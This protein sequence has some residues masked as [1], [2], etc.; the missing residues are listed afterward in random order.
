MKW[1]GQGCPKKTLFVLTY[2][3]SGWVWPVLV[4]SFLGYEWNGMDQE[5]GCMH[6]IIQ[7]RKIGE[8][9]CRLSNT[10]LV[11]LALWSLR[12]TTP[13]CFG[14]RNWAVDAYIYIYT[15]WTALGNLIVSLLS[16]G[17]TALPAWVMVMGISKI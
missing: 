15:H 10:L 13:P 5:E 7:K 1:T 6:H 8:V 2:C 16:V 3:I 9:V 4:L 14:M 12:F 11:R 17:L